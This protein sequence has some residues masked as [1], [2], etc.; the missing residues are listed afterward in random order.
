[1]MNDVGI[2]DVL[3]IVLILAVIHGIMR[4]VSCLRAR[5]QNLEADSTES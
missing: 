2:G 3:F 5:K 1:M 4:W